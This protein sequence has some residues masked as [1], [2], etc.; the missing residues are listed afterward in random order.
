MMY[1]PL[2]HL[3]IATT[4]NNNSPT[5]FWVWPGLANV[6]FQR[7]T[8]IGSSTSC[9]PVEYDLA[10]TYPSP[11]NPSTTT[12]CKLPKASM[13]TVSVYD[14][15]GREVFILVNGRESAGSCEVKFDGSNLACGVYFYRLQA[16]SFVKTMKCLLFR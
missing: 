14:I 11:F 15:L 16:G 6:Y 4:E 13:V 3:G 10:Q 9:T 5:Q 12:G 1:C 2:A 7:Q 8:G